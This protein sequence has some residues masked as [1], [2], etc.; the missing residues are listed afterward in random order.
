MSVGIYESP[1][2][3]LLNDL[4]NQQ[5]K[6]QTELTIA[7]DE[8]NL[9]IAATTDFLAFLKLNDTQIPKLL[10]IIFLSVDLLINQQIFSVSFLT[11]HW[12]CVQSRALIRWSREEEL[13]D[14]IF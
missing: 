1:N 3:L 7:E 10:V 4:S 8:E 14:L 11:F 9:Q 6:A 13:S 2:W 5:S 12:T